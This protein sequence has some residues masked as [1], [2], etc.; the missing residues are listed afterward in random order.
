MYMVR[1]LC[2]NFG[3]LEGFTEE[4]ENAEETKETGLVSSRHYLL[5]GL[6]L[7]LHQSLQKSM[8]QRHTKFKFQS[9]SF[10]VH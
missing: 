6:L 9:T 8:I 1:G 4:K 2:L 7:A 3:F 10:L 5:I